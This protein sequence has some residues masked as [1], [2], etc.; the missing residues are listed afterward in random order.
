MV[1]RGIG[2]ENFEVTMRDSDHGKQMAEEMMMEPFLDS[3]P[4]LTGRT[5]EIISQ[6][7]S[8]DFLALIDGRETG[9][10]LTKIH[11]ETPDDYLDEVIRLA[12]KKETSYD[13]RGVFSRPTILLCYGDHPPIFDMLGF[14]DGSPSW[15]DLTDSKF[16]EIWL[17]D[18]SDEYYSAQD[19]RK[20]AD[21]YCLSPADLR[22]FYEL[23]RT[24]KPY[25]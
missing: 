14:L 25:G 6:G 20:P 21:L 23:P 8:P 10:E 24:R 7:E 15:A 13:Q 5:V 17:M 4:R 19:P 3:Y 12:L 1:A 18:L 11:A 2:G 16:T 22:G 9:I